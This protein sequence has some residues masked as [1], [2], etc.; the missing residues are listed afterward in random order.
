MKESGI[1][2]LLASQ[3]NWAFSVF[4]GGIPSDTF[5]YLNI[6][7]AFVNLGSFIVAPMGDCY[8]KLYTRFAD[9]KA[10][11]PGFET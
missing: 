3:I 7:F 2:R 11:N 8:I 6:A 10:T 5:T 4:S 1:F 9:L